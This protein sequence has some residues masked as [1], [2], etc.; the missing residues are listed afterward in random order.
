M[1]AEFLKVL[2]FV[3][4]CCGRAPH[5]PPPA[6]R[7]FPAYD[8]LMA[9]LVPVFIVLFGVMEPLR[10]YLGFSGNLQEKV[11]V[12]P[13]LRRHSFLW[14]LCFG[15]RVV[16]VVLV[17]VLSVFQVSN[18]SAFFLLTIIPGLPIVAFLSFLQR[19]QFPVETIMGA[20]YIVFIV[21]V[22]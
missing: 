1:P 22:D 14:G 8:K 10:V 17:V 3:L 5:P 7:R 20:I 2:F 6:Q 16:S 18:L 21:R 13:L 12:N 9:P 11:G 15:T 19:D 4:N